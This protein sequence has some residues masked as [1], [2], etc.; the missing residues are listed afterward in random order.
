MADEALKVVEEIKSLVVKQQEEFSDLQKKGIVTSDTLETMRTELDKKME[1]IE[2]LN[3]AVEGEKKA[4]ENL[5]LIIARGSEGSKDGKIVG[6]E[7][8]RKKFWKE[9]AYNCKEID[10]GSVGKEIDAIAKSLKM[11]PAEVKSYIVGS[12]PNGGYMAPTEFRNEVISRVFETSPIRQVANVITSASG[13]VEFPIDDTD[14]D[15]SWIGEVDPMAETKTNT[16]GVADIDAH[17][18]VAKQKIS[19]TMLEDSVLNIEQF[20]RNKVANKIGRLENTAFISGSGTKKPM[21]I[22]TYA[23]WANVEQYETGKLAAYTTAASGTLTADDLIIFQS[24]LLEDYQAN[25]RFMVNRQVWASNIVTLKDQ[26]D[27]YLLNPMML[28]Q[29]TTPQLLGKPVTFASDL[30]SAV[31]AG[32]KGALLYGDFRAGYTIV[33]RIGI[34]VIRDNVT[35]DR[36]VRLKFRKRT[37]GAV[38]NYQAIKLLSIKS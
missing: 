2:S 23:N 19:F 9:F 6:D 29:G 3:A 32:V 4:R 11:E 16:F 27:N 10:P 37:G 18:L 30:P 17:E 13:R 14:T 1:K 21:G 28:F 8:Y 5:E 24:K 35:D 7:S 26:E 22:L 34:N 25:G 36:F 15:A 38:T 12:N 20:V 31:S 33:D